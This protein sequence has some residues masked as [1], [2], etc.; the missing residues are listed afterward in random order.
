M[1]T[2]AEAQPILSIDPNLLEGSHSRFTAININTPGTTAVM[3]SYGMNS[4]SIENTYIH[5]SDQYPGR[6]LDS[7][8]DLGVEADAPVYSE[9]QGRWVTLYMNNVARN[10]ATPQPEHLNVPYRD[11][12][13]IA[14]YR[15]LVQHAGQVSEHLVE[16][17]SGRADEVNMGRDGL[18]AEQRKA[19]R[20]LA[21][22]TAVPRLLG[23]IASAAVSVTG[24]ILN[25]KYNVVP[26]GIAYG[27]GGLATALT[28]FPLLAGYKLAYLEKYRAISEAQRWPRHLRAKERAAAYSAARDAGELPELVEYTLRYEQ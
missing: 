6:P 21:R 17:L 2:P 25:H 8:R 22:R 14:R 24:V 18:E 16:A 1:P 15:D 27:A 9:A 20:K 13:R 28:C 4:Q 10:L 11:E 12:S 3:R 7:L 5:L 26:T 23:S 19:E